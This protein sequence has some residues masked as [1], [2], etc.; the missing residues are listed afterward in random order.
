MLSSTVTLTN[1]YTSTHAHTCIHLLYMHAYTCIHTGFICTVH[2]HVHAH[3]MYTN[4][5]SLSAV[6]RWR[7]VIWLRDCRYQKDGTHLLEALAHLGGRGRR[8]GRRCR[9]ENEGGKMYMNV[10]KTLVVWYT[11]AS[12]LCCTCM[13][14]NT[15]T[16]SH[17]SAADEAWYWPKCVLHIG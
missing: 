6:Q 13:S 15:H 10:I 12:H 1:F 5:V 2:V 11:K 9:E 17:P 8:R 16:P 7:G 4:H 3:C 14:C